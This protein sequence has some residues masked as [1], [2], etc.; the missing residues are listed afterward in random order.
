MTAFQPVRP[1]DFLSV[2]SLDHPTA[3]G[4]GFPSLY[5]IASRKGVRRSYNSSRSRTGAW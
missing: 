4:A 2:S 5:R 1:N 3:A